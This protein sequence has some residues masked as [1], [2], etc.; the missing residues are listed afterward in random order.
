MVIWQFFYFRAPIFK[1]TFSSRKPPVFTRIAWTLITAKKF[2]NFFTDKM[3]TPQN[4]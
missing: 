2:N 4:P 3:S 1:N